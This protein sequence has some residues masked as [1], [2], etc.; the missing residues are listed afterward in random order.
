MTKSEILRQELSS[1]P[2]KVAAVRRRVLA[3]QA[4]RQKA[5]EKVK[6]G[7]KACQVQEKMGA[8]EAAIIRR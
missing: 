8:P 4:K 3:G 7:E 2:A 5:I 6:K 1:S